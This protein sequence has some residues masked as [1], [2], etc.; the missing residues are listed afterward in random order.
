MADEAPQS[1]AAGSSRG[2]KVA[3][4]AV[5]AIAVI[6]IGTAYVLLKPPPVVVNEAVV[7]PGDGA[8]SLQLTATLADGSYHLM[9]DIRIR[10]APVEVTLAGP[11]VIEELEGKRSTILDV[12]TT[13]ANSLDQ[14]TVHKAGEFKSRVKREL[15]K[16]IESAE[17]QDILIENWLVNPVE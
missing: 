15:S 3:L 4:I 9:T 7:W 2:L 8:K 5:I 6:G 17:I 10:T 13:V 1:P 16:E 12:L 14:A 11:K